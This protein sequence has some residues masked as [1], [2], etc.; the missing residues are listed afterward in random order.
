MLAVRVYIQVFSEC[1]YSCLYVC[2]YVQVASVYIHVL[3]P[4]M[5]AHR[6]ATALGGGGV[7]ISVLVRCVHM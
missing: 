6:C 3:V 4:R 5:H 7:Y 1:V 2:V